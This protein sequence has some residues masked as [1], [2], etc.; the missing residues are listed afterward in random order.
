MITL[1]KID[2]KYLVSGLEWR[3]LEASSSVADDE[4][5]EKK[6]FRLYK[7]PA[8]EEA[9]V[10]RN[11]AVMLACGQSTHLRG[12]L[13]KEGLKDVGKTPMFA[14]L[15]SVAE[16]F[17]GVPSLPK[18]AVLVAPLLDN[19]D[20]FVLSVA[21]GG[22]PAPDP[23]FDTVVRREEVAATL[24]SWKFE[25]TDSLSLMPVL[26]GVWSEAR[27]LTLSE[28]L[29]T[30]VHNRPMR[31][32]GADLRVVAPVMIAVIALGGA[33]YA[34]KVYQQQK[35]AKIARA[36]ALKNDPVRKYTAAL[37]TEWPTIVWNSTPRV[38]ELVQKAAAL[39]L[40]VGGFSLD[41][42]VACDI[43]AASCKLKY[44]RNSGTFLTFESAA[45]SAIKVT[46]YGQDGKTITASIDLAISAPTGAPTSDWSALPLEPRIPLEFWPPIHVL[47][48]KLVAGTLS[49]D[50][51]LFPAVP[52][53]TG[54][55]LP[56][57]VRSVSVT[58][59]Y[60]VWAASTMPI[61]TDAYRKMVNWKTATI[62]VATAHVTLKGEMYAQK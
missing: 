22:E 43:V 9:F 8:S 60:P 59:D 52:E 23:R 56:H 13:T 30:S 17:S 45:G 48:Q 38:R 20:Y 28:M 15:Y 3:P 25:L 54:I 36:N 35:A 37:V 4:A 47:P 5:A 18:C 26:Y 27:E 57:S 32:I 49:T 16:V 24:E 62:N 50:Y 11:R 41:G 39:P 19:P 34:N 29:E 2:G 42:D 51:K 44:K 7:D 33:F 58:F 31:R 14:K 1:L 40:S 12:F 10:K 53:A 6:S 55:A 21:I 46:E 61:D